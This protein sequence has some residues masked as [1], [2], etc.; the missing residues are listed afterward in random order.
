M[1]KQGNALIA[2]GLA[3]LLAAL[4][5]VGYN[6]W[7]DG[8]AGQS[9]N[10]ALAELKTVLE[11]EN[12]EEAL[13][14]AE[15][16]AQ[17]SEAFLPRIDAWNGEGEL[18]EYL[19]DPQRDMPERTVSQ[20]SYIGV[21][22]IPALSLELPVISE[23]SYP[24]LRIAP[25]RYTGSAYQNDL[26]I[27]AHNYRSHFGRLQ[28]LSTGDEVTFTDMEGTVFSY[29][30]AEVEILPPDAVS[31]MT[32]GQWALTLFTCTV[33]GQSRVTVRCELL[34]GGAAA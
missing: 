19:R 27:A 8:E 13:D 31:E 20:Q 22:R 10:T 2:A 9:A 33:G 15:T 26:V 32:S 4:A 5:L 6:F 11:E 25:C 24:R 12:G 29:R 1:T 28:T 3:L 14:G 21:L 23:W 17:E 18:P 30:V 16:G 34:E 7:S